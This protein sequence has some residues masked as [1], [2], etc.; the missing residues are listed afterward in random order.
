[1]LEKYVSK[2][3]ILLCSFDQSCVYGGVLEALELALLG[4]AGWDSEG[5]DARREVSYSLHWCGD[6]FFLCILASLGADSTFILGME[7][8]RAGTGARRRFRVSLLLNIY[9]N[10]S[11]I[12][13]LI[14]VF[15][16]RTSSSRCVPS[17][18]L[19]RLDL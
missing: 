18:R 12:A 15:S 10:M 7:V 8:G 4:M 17:F 9:D 2:N 19:I 14:D 11:R 1:M 16:F 6:L 3:V 13:I 5:S